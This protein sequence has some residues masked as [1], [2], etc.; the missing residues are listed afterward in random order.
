MSEKNCTSLFVPKGFAH[1]YYSYENLNVIYYKIS[2]YY[3]PGYEDG[4]IWNDKS[5]K[6]NWPN[7]KPLLSAKDKK[8]GT[9][10][11][12]KHKFKGL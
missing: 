3:K 9:F 10:N 12:F 2:D 7:K 8:H 11:A 6:I 4:I 1:A 5:F